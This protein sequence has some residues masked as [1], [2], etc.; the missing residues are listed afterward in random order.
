M[1]KTTLSNNFHLV[2]TKV[3][4][5]FHHMFYFFITVYHRALSLGVVSVSIPRRVLFT[6]FHFDLCSYH[7]G[8]LTVRGFLYV[9]TLLPNL[10]ED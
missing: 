2:T 9:Y 1:P 8:L 10:V 6:A 3:T 7:R 4:Q 5:F